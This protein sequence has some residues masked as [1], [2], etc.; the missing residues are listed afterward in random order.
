MAVAMSAGP[1][2]VVVDFVEGV[3][4]FGDP[5]TAVIRTDH[6]TWVAIRNAPAFLLAGREGLVAL[7]SAG[8]STS[9]RVALAFYAPASTEVR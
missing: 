2:G 1:S 9:G 8:D 6:G 5:N 3:L 4:N 7:A